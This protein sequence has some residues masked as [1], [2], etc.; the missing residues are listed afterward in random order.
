MDEFEFTES[1]SEESTESSSEEL[2]SIQRP[3][4]INENKEIDPTEPID[5]NESN[6]Q[7]KMK[8]MDAQGQ[9]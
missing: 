7:V 5:T 1:V 2:S 4:I 3:D 9:K 6:D 8:S